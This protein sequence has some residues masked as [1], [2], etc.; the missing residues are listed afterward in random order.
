VTPIG[1]QNSP[2]PLKPLGLRKKKQAKTPIF[3]FAKKDGFFSRTFC[4][5]V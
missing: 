1:Q 5:L 4:D 2:G 3:D